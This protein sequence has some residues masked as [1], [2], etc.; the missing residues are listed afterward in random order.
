MAQVAARAGLDAHRPRLPAESGSMID[1]QGRLGLPL[2]HHLVEHRPLHLHPSV[3]QVGPAQ[4]DFEHPAASRIH[5]ELPEPGAHPAR[6]PEGNRRQ[7]AAEMLGVEPA[8]HLR[9]ALLNRLVARPRPLD[10][11][12]ARAGGRRVRLDR[13][14]QELALRAPARGPARAGPHVPHDGR[15]HPVGRPG[16]APVHPQ[17]SARRDAEQD[18]PVGVRREPAERRHPQRI[19]PAAQHRLGGLRRRGLP[20]QPHDVPPDGRMRDC[21]TRGTPAPR[22]PTA[23]TPPSPRPRRCAPR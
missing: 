4:R 9:K 10:A 22:G 14:G 16:V 13:K 3:S 12:P 2:V 17:D 5:R 15:E 6:E 18:R 20:P 7:G 21:P 23:R 11:A 1:G 8:V 19:Q